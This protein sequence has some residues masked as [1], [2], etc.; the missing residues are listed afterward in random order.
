MREKKTGEN[1]SLSLEQLLT[2]I[3]SRSFS[4]YERLEERH[5]SEDQ[6]TSPPSAF[7]RLDRWRKSAA[8]GDEARFRKR[9][10]WDQLDT[11]TVLRV[12]GTSC[13]WLG[14]PPRWLD[15]LTEYMNESSDAKAVWRCKQ[16]L[17]DPTEPLPFEH[18]FIPLVDVA[19]RRLVRRA[20]GAL[21]RLS[22]Q[23]RRQ[24]GR[25][26]LRRLT[27][28]SAHVLGLEFDVYRGLHQDRITSFVRSRTAP[29]SELYARFIEK[30][31]AE[32]CGS[33]FRRYPVLARLLGTV[34]TAWVEATV[35]FLQ[36]LHRDWEL[37]VGTFSDGVSCG[38][39]VELAPGLSDPHNGQRTVIQVT[40]NDRMSLIYK[41]REL[42][43]DTAFNDLLDW[44]NRRVGR[45]LVRPVR[46][47]V[48]DGYGWTEAVRH[49]PCATEADAEAYFERAGALICL[50]Y[51]LDGTDCHYENVVA[52]G[53]FPVLVDLETLLHPRL[54]RQD[55][56]LDLSADAAATRQL[57]DSVFRTGMLPRWVANGDNPPVDL[58][59]LGAADEYVGHGSHHEWININTDAMALCAVEAKRRVITNLP[60]IGGDVVEPHQYVMAISR[61]FRSLYW[62]ICE[63]R[64]ELLAK[65]GALS[66]LLATKVRC[67]FR[68]TR[69]YSL[70]LERTLLPDAMSDGIERSI[71]L[72]SLSLA[73]LNAVARPSAWA[74]VQA[75]HKALDALDVPIFYATADKTDLY[76]AEGSEVRDLFE[77]SSSQIVRERICKM[78]ETDLNLQERFIKASL[79]QR[80]QTSLHV[81][82]RA[83]KAAE[84][85]QGEAPHKE[86]AYLEE[87]WNIAKALQQEA[88]AGGDGSVTWLTVEALP[89]S[90]RYQYQP[91][92]ATLFAGIA[93]I[94]L[95]LA[96]S[97]RA[98]NDSSLRA[99]ALAAAQTIEKRLSS[100]GPSL[101]AEIG[102]AQRRVLAQLYTALRV[103][104]NSWGRRNCF[105]SPRRA[106]S[107]SPSTA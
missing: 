83:A 1:K 13:C 70:L 5:R 19:G 49:E 92:A 40:L 57:W 58:S 10:A 56:E 68:D 60:R 6:G 32:K 4:L 53:E 28:I 43:T 26:L 37:L 73:F 46:T 62:L 66:A 76:F 71:L 85:E 33:L 16:L 69:V 39:V 29:S 54:T 90:G 2:E 82:E 51:L 103:W 81:A 18:L 94:G 93:G 44:I 106:Q 102:L 21:E 14:E 48:C 45:R 17:L 104:P 96:A 35:E 22:V 3:L 7:E 89:W 34:A 59:A 50:V 101:V 12:L 79:I 105:R 65:N 95:F 72:D 41:P 25:Q 99:T 74:I 30:H 80:S 64:D 75:E 15:V 20:G 61:G 87:A 36:R 31:A 52:E 38:P 67:V 77:R 100:S 88:V 23:A 11:D 97:A 91:A 98:F 27:Q 24:L 9:L 107:G 84:E 86:V 8:R 55:G 42:R 63:N 47:V 78:S